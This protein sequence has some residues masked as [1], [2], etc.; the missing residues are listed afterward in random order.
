MKQSFIVEDSS[1]FPGFSPP[2]GSPRDNFRAARTN[3]EGA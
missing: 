1:D 3:Q 2:S